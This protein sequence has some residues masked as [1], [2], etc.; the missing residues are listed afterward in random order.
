MKNVFHAIVNH[1]F[2]GV[3]MCLAFVISISANIY[4]LVLHS[5]GEKKC[6]WTC[7][8]KQF[9]TRRSRKK[10]VIYGRLCFPL[11]VFACFYYHTCLHGWFLFYFLH[12]IFDKSHTFYVSSSIQKNCPVNFFVHLFSV[13]T[14]EK[15]V[16]AGLVAF[17]Q[18]TDNNRNSSNGVR[19]TSWTIIIL[20]L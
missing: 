6:K 3:S 4:Q 10:T 5:W 17:E 15:Q 16:M 14:S 18:M 8:D 11:L 12:C 2:G 9:I 19:Y 20:G 7:L 13:V 1:P